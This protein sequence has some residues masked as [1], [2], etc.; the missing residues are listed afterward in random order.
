MGG[1]SDFISMYTSW[2]V[3]VVMY[4]ILSIKIVQ[5]ISCLS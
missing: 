2:E 3:S 5:V 4:S 1:G